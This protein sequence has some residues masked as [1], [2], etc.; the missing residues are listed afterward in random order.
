[1]QNSM[2]PNECVKIT[3]EQRRRWMP[4]AHIYTHCNVGTIPCTLE[5][6]CSRLASLPMLA[7]FLSSS[8]APL[9]L[10]SAM[11]LLLP[12]ALVAL[13]AELPEPGSATPPK[14]ILVNARTEADRGDENDEEE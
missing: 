3:E 6:P 11:A 14:A 12:L 7:T 13:L 10:G 4:G 8:P 9:A 5:R 2:I 1:M